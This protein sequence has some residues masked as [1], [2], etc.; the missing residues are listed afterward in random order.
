MPYDGTVLDRAE[1]LADVE[2]RTIHH[3]PHEAFVDLGVRPGLRSPDLG[4]VLPEALRALRREGVRRAV[5]AL[6]AS[7]PVCAEVVP[8]LRDAVDVVRQV[9]TRRAGSS[10][11]LTIEL[12]LADAASP[13]ASP[14]P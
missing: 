12:G 8:A 11:M 5:M 7:D 2:V 13:T 1:V 3:S 14:R 6:E 10:I 9:T 4:T